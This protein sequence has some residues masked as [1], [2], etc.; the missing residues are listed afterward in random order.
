M[1][2]KTM[3]LQDLVDAY[4]RH[5]Y[6]YWVE[7]NPEISDQEFDLIER[8]LRQLDP[9]N[10][11]L[12][13]LHHAPINSPVN[14]DP[15]MLSQNKAYSKEEIVK[16]AKD[17]GD[18]KFMVSPKMDGCACEL[19][20]FKGRL[21]QASTRGTGTKGEDV[22]QN[23]LKVKNIP[24]SI[25]HKGTV[26]VRGEIVMPLSVFN[27]NFK[28]SNSNPRN[29]ASGSLK[30]KD[31]SESEKRGLVFY[32]Y[33]II[34]N[35]VLETEGQ[36]F[37]FLRDNNFRTVEIHF[38]T[39][40]TLEEV[41]LNFMNKR[42]DLDFEIDGVVFTVNQV[43]NQQQLGRNSHHPRYSIAWKF[44][45]ESNTTI[46]KD[47]EW[48]ISRTGQVTPVAIVEPVELSGATIERSTIHHA[49]FVISKKLSK[50]AVVEMTRR[51]GVIPHIER[52]VKAGS[53][54]FEIPKE[55]NG[56]PVEMIDDF[57]YLKN[58]ELHP[59]V[60]ISRLVHFCSVIEADGWGDKILAQL[61][62][63]GIV[64]S[65]VDLFTLTGADL[66]NGIDRSGDKM[67]S[68]LLT[69]INKHRTIPLST[70]I[71]SIG[72]DELG[73][74][75]SKDIAKRFKNLDAVRKVTQLELEVMDGIG[76][77]IAIAVVLGLQK[78][79]DMI[80]KLLKQVKVLDY[81]DVCDKNGKLN[82][83]SFLFTGTLEGMGRKEA[84]DLVLKNGGE[85][86]SSVSK[87]L[88]Y[89]VVGGDEKDSSK[90][91]KALKLNDQG[92]TIKVIN[93]KEFLVLIESK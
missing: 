64:K 35:N 9:K 65:I 19:K 17:T 83:Q 14:H 28:D 1:D 85:I 58:P 45:G 42:D 43:S 57:L 61:Y 4:V 47:I 66:M 86:S 73:R 18:L 36:E 78:N 63:R 34:G 52:V 81:E 2:I 44:Q 80:D 5:N 16:W 54:L 20:Y 13:K 3:T 7:N 55:V 33:E 62:N 46:L 88:T 79:S 50:G 38:A 40:D 93:E 10:S 92:A 70:F 56:H 15:P 21:V 12:D 41:Y 71:R 23:I 68:K 76:S 29:L 77:K 31:S 27:K 74:S 84:Q 59:E 11:V 32:A 67:I 39:I 24:H 49:G 91:K 69:E 89:L 82:G 87:N 26:F 25:S 75:V 30:H 22:T 60:Q 8:H 90:S 6:L 72:I 53:K 48:S 51:G 37:Q